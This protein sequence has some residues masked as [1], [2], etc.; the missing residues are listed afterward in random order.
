[1]LLFLGLALQ[2]ETPPIEIKHAPGDFVTVNGAKLWYESEGTGEPLVLIAGGPG[3]AHGYFHPFFS[4]LAA[5]NRIIYFDAFG[6][7]KSDRAKSPAEYTFTRDVDDV[8]GLRQGLGLGKINLL[9]HSYGGMVAQAYALKYPESVKR[10]ILAD[11][12][13]SGEMWQAN[14]DNS[15]YE[16]RNQLPETWEKVQKVRAEGY[17]S[18]AKEHQK[19]YDLPVG[20]LF[21]YD[22]SNA[23]KVHFDFNTEVYYAIV[24]DDGDFLIGGD[25]AKL[26]F[27]LDLKKLTMP[28]LILMGRYDR[29]SLPRYAL[30][31]KTYAPRAQCVMFEK[32]GHFPFVEENAETMKVLREFLAK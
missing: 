13:F 19:A 17:R 7:G 4:S 20:L 28:T 16:A 8:E 32:S 31:F 21:F 22:A 3:G 6:R 24:G 26:D 27:R 5:S 1:L 18:S 14:N 10:L 23:E 9:G 15:N 2:A 25:I 11:T 30:Q 12:L 29:T